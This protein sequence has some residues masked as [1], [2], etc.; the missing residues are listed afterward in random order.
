MQ[1][2]I[3]RKMLKNTMEKNKRGNAF[4]LESSSKTKN[5]NRKAVGIIHYL[6]VKRHCDDELKTYGDFGNNK[7][8]TVKMSRDQ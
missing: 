2:L 3:E 5:I 4:V 7:S 1:K 6:L 8:G